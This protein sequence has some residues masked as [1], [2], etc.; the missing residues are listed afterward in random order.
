MLSA[1]NELGAS[2]PVVGT[3]SALVDAYLEAF[4]GGAHAAI[5]RAF[6]VTVVLTGISRLYWSLVRSTE[7]AVVEHW[8]RLCP[9]LLA[10]AP[11]ESDA[12]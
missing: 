2:A 8:A 12:P 10:L 4:D 3:A 7:P 6:T 5:R 1:L 9:W 11:A